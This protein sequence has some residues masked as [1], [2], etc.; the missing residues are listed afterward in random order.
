[1]TGSIC[2]I[3]NKSVMAIVSKNP[4]NW[5]IL[6]SLV[7]VAQAVSLQQ[8]Y[9]AETRHCCFLTSEIGNLQLATAQYNDNGTI[10]CKYVVGRRPR[11][12]LMSCYFSDM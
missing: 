4:A 9:S 5:K 2:G 1:L 6:F 10:I 11:S 12:M 8:P 7:V 3:T